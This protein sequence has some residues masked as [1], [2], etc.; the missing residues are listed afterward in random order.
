MLRAVSLLT[1]VDVC[2]CVETEEERS[3]GSGLSA[4]KSSE[5]FLLAA[6]QNKHD[7]D[8]ACRTCHQGQTTHVQRASASSIIKIWIVLAASVHQHLPLSRH[9]S[10]LPP[11]AFP[12]PKHIL[13]HTTPPADCH[14]FAF[15]TA[16]KQKH[17]HSAAPS[18]LA[19]A[20]WNMTCRL[21]SDLART[22]F[23]TDPNSKHKLC[24]CWSCPT[25]QE[26]HLGFPFSESVGQLFEACLVLLSTLLTACVPGTLDSRRV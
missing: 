18:G 12:L 6:A 17:R 15:I 9:T 3:R 20:T 14:P 19:S 1:C 16:A 13:I 23:V 21:P 22:A 25:N 10:P 7:A 26:P 4:S 11:N 5:A 2:V 8:A 24:P